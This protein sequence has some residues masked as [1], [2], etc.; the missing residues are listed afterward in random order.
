MPCTL[1]LA[2]YIANRLAD[3]AEEATS[4]NAIQTAFNDLV[5]NQTMAIQNIDGLAVV[6]DFSSVLAAL[7]HSKNDALLGIKYAAE[8]FD[9]VP[10]DPNIKYFDFFDAKNKNY[11]GKANLKKDPTFISSTPVDNKAALHH[12]PTNVF[13]LRPDVLN[14]I[15]K[16]QQLDPVY[17]KQKA[18]QPTLLWQYV[19]SPTGVFSMYPGFFWAD[20]DETDRYDCRRRGWYMLGASSSKDAVILIDTSGSMTGVNMNI[21]IAAADVLIKSFQ[22]NDFFN[23][24]MFN[25]ETDLAI[26]CF[27]NLV[28]STK[29][30]REKFREKLFNLSSPSSSGNIVKAL[31]K[32]YDMLR[33]AKKSKLTTSGCHRSIF[34]LS[35]ELEQLDDAKKVRIFSY[36]IGLGNKKK[37]TLEHI[38]CRSGGK[39]YQLET[40][41]DVYDTVLDYVTQLGESI[42]SNKTADS[43]IITYVPLYAD[44]STKKLVIS[45]VV[46]IVKQSS[47]GLFGVAG[48]DITME[49]LAD[50]APIQKLGIS[51]YGFSVNNN[52]FALFH[53][54]LRAQQS[55]FK[56]PPTV[57]L[58]ALEL[59]S[60]NETRVLMKKMIDRMTG[61]MNTTNYMVFPISTR[62]RFMQVDMHYFFAPTNNTPFTSGIAIPD[63]GIKCLVL[64]NAQ[65]N[66]TEA[67]TSLN[68]TSQNVSIMIPSW[69][70][71]NIT[72]KL[73]IN[74][75]PSPII[76]PDRQ[77]L[78]DYLS[79]FSQIPPSCNKDLLE[80]LFLS[81]KVLDDLLKQKWNATKNARNHV[82]SSFVS[83]HSG[84]TR[85]VYSRINEIKSGTI[86]NEATSEE[87]YARA[88]DIYKQKQNHFIYDVKDDVTDKNVIIASSPVVVGKDLQAVA[89]VVG[90][91][92]S[93]SALTDMIKN[94]SLG[95]KLDFNCDQNK[96]FGCYIVDSDG[97]IVAGNRNQS[98]VS[99]FFGLTEGNVMRD[100]I[101]KK[102]F[103]RHTILDEQAECS[104]T[105]SKK[106]SASRITN[107]SLQNYCS[108]AVIII[109]ILSSIMVQLMYGSSKVDAATTKYYNCI[110]EMYFFKL[111]TT[112]L[113]YEGT[114][115]QLTC[116]KKYSLAAL[117]N[118][119]LALI[120]TDRRNTA[121]NYKDWKLDP[122]PVESTCSSG[123]MKASSS[124]G[125]LR[126]TLLLLLAFYMI[127][128]D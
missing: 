66:F 125:I 42:T 29:T 128:C 44:Y 52:G 63:F 97:Y 16:S 54:F 92:M 25:S 26:S 56:L 71:C 10:D 89:A 84:Y 108:K 98:L 7:L 36:Q 120:I 68:D 67:L 2:D 40:I 34:L 86:G 6:K 59:N 107:V 33:V 17:E 38:A 88:A 114:T 85:V 27:P 19:G 58:T 18:E 123:E 122:S 117:A 100:L 28:Q 78:L 112:M 75:P 103:N 65:F 91:T 45:V 127:N 48:Q 62:K 46:P 106:S 119:N 101:K 115:T 110:K 57:P 109:R 8:K 77:E 23:M 51:G 126:T 118:T 50:T 94:F 121:C 21:A 105:S 4:Q 12:I 82:L 99:R 64:K 79:K 14:Y 3:I 55:Q 74:K 116:N 37:N 90:F 81:A 30:S 41:G 73:Q 39:Y 5:T 95:A 124:F 1:K 113:P 11:S 13:K 61:K 35:D 96:D 102:I 24:M 53:P 49:E 60:Q 32:A 70:F 69:S 80:K 104:D 47:S 15:N 20:T 31:V 72:S 83:T 43:G 111:N 9:K 76:Y 93:Q 22:E 87:F